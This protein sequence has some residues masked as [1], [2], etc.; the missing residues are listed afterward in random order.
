MSTLDLF[1]LTSKTAVVIGGEGLLGKV[2]CE[3]VR[4]LGGTPVSV[5]LHVGA[6][7]VRDITDLPSLIEV[8]GYL[9]R[10]DIVIN[11]AIGNQKPM[12][13]PT[14]LWDEDIAIGLTGASNV[15]IAFRDKIIASK[16]VFLTIGSDLSLTAPDPA[17]YEPEFKPLSYSVVKH[18]IIGMTRYY[19][20][21]WGRHGVRVNCLCPGGIEQGQSVPRCPLERLAQSHEMKGALA[22]MI[23]AASSYMTGAI[24][25]VDGGRTITTG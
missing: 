18:G 10:I 12:T 1:C 17:R 20:A 24:V 16:G 9:P 4:E 25:V 7:Y 22:F 19:A 15:F 2:V 23:S 21:L 8:E 11:C 5:D 6:S 13:F 3:T 14:S